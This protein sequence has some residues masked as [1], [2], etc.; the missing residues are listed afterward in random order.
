M[1]FGRSFGF[2]LGM[3]LVGLATLYFFSHTTTGT[4]LFFT[5]HGKIPDTEPILD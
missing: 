2:V 1:S 4:K 3:I 5:V